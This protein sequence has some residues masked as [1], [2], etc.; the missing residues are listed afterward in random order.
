MLT[1]SP[2]HEK[3]L[4]KSLI[5]GTTSYSQ[6]TSSLTKVCI[7]MYST[8]VWTCHVCVCVCAGVNVCSYM[9]AIVSNL[10]NE[11]SNG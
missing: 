5:I 1:L 4:Y 11:A 2:P 6:C 10:P 8:N 7:Q 3:I 9:Y